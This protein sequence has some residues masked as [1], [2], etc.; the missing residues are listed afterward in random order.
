M[1]QHSDDYVLTVPESQLKRQLSAQY[2]SEEVIE[3]ASIMIYFNEEQNEQINRMW[4][5][6][7]CFNINQVPVWVWILLAALIVGG[8]AFWLWRRAV[9]NRQYE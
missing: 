3:R 8:V 5:N 2:P 9:R 4:T 7:R 1:G 6:V